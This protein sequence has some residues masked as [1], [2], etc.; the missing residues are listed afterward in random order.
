[1]GLATRRLQL[2]E[3]KGFKENRRN[4][5]KRAS[6]LG[7]EKKNARRYGVCQP[8]KNKSVGLTRKGETRSDRLVGGG[9]RGLRGVL[10]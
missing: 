4:K 5:W 1:M 3:K 6:L 7:V 2:P 8:E 10:N 9:G